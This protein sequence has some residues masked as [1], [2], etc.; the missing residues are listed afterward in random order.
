MGGVCAAVEE[1]KW[2]EAGCGCGGEEGSGEEERRGPP[3]ARTQVNGLRGARGRI[4]HCSRVSLALRWT[5]QQGSS[6]PAL[7]ARV[8][9]FL[10]RCTQGLPVSRT[11]DSCVGQQASSCSLVFVSTAPLADGRWFRGLRQC[12]V[13]GVFCSNSCGPAARWV[14]CGGGR[15]TSLEQFSFGRLGR[16]NQRIWGVAADQRKTTCGNI[17]WSQASLLET[18]L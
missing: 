15:V 5:T 17:L 14:D 1:F 6:C 11:C 12:W 4:F 8:H 7:G 10:P 3:L 16:P 13:P 2:R 18:L 9:C